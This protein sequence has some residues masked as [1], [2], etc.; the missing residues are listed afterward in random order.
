[1]SQIGKVAWADSYIPNVSIVIPER[2]SPWWT[3]ETEHQVNELNC[4]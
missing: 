2:I 3:I 4:I 1:M